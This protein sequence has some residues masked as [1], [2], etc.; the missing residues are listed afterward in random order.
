MVVLVG[1]GL[2]GGALVRTPFFNNTERLPGAAPL[3][4]NDGTW[5]ELEL[6]NEISGLERP[7]FITHAGDGSGRIFV[8]EQEGRIRIIR[9]GALLETPFLNI[10]GRVLCCGERGLLS[11]AFP[12]DYATTG[13]LYVYYTDQNNNGATV[14]S[15]FSISD[16]PDRADGTSEEV[17]LT[18]DQ[19]FDNHNG[20]QLAF[21]PNDGYLYIGTGD[22][23]SGGDPQDRAQTTSDLLGKILRID[24][25]RT[26]GELPY[27]IPPTNPYTQTAGYAPEIWALGLRNPWR[28]SFD[29]ATGDLYI[30]DVGQGSIEEISYQPAAST[31]GE[32]YGWRCK[33]GSNDFNMS[34]DCANL[35]LVDPVVEYP[36]DVSCSVT[37]GYVYRGPAFPLMQGVYIYGDYC[38]GYV[39]GLR[40]NSEQNWEN[41]LLLETGFFGSLSSFGEDEAG[42]LYIANLANG[43]IVQVIDTAAPPPATATPTTTATTEPVT[44]PTTTPTATPDGNPTDTTLLW[45][46]AVV[47]R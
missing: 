34:D 17:L 12:P 41:I 36:H 47:R 27:A 30:G 16:D 20:G 21:G 15:R 26:M 1:G 45:L 43:A 19:P 10:P 2:F 7:V 13:Q 3:A 6:G 22:G 31:G 28:F 32:N 24:V 40:R 4:Q 14:V 23:G 42:N 11:V 9:D 33:E 44:A 29:R 18:I 25:T 37:G 46:P 39:W 5:P 8:V 38:S 35:Q